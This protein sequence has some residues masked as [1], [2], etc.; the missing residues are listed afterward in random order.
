MTYV[1]EI[2]LDGHSMFLPEALL[3]FTGIVALLL[4]PCVLSE[5]ININN[6]ACLACVFAAALALIREME[7]TA[8]HRTSEP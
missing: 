3:L 6:H 4:L 2:W 5:Y 7:A 8:V 1:L